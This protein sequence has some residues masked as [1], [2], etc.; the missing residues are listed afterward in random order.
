MTKLLKYLRSILWR[1]HWQYRNP[2]DRTCKVCGRH[3]VGHSLPWNWN[4]R[5]KWWWEVFNEGNIERHTEG[6]NNDK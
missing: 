3:E 2:F 5:F 6:K 1:H 4:H